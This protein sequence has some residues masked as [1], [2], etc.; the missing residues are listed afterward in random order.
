M[1]ISRRRLIAA[2]LALD[3]SGRLSAAQPLDPARTQFYAPTS[4]ADQP[5]FLKWA[6]IFSS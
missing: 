5:H 3:V 6:V 2:G 1:T 4:S